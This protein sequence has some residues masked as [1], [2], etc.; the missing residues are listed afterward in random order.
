MARWLAGQRRKNASR[1]RDWFFPISISIPPVLSPPVLPFHS[2]D[3]SSY[4]IILPTKER[5]ADAE[6]RQLASRYCQLPRR[7]PGRCESSD[8]RPLSLAKT[9]TRIIILLVVFQLTRAIHTVNSSSIFSCC[10]IQ[11]LL[12]I[13]SFFVFFSSLNIFLPIS[14]LFF[15]SFSLL[16]SLLSLLYF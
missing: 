10:F 15:V 14:L 6:R 13:N 2:A 16:S 1:R 3:C 5:E 7:F 4:V 8:T 12:F 9:P 11:F